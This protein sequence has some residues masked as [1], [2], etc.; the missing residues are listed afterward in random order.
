MRRETRS[1]LRDT[2]GTLRNTKK[3]LRETKRT[4]RSTKRILR[5]TKRM[6]RGTKGTLPD[7]QDKPS[8]DFKIKKC[9]TTSFKTQ[10]S[11]KHFSKLSSGQ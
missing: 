2:K 10:P 4:L 7:K 5:D 3:T 8:H 9:N 1:I 11:P 6:L